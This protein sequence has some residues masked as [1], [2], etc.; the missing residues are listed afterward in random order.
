MT[1]EADQAEHWESMEREAALARHANRPSAPLPMCEACEEVPVHVDARG[2]RWRFCADC[3]EE[4][5][6]RNR[7]A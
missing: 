2:T 6:R 4:H 3:A 1:D 5:L 7:I